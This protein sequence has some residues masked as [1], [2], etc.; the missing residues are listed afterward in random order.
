MTG[1]IERLI[2]ELESDDALDG[3]ERLRQRI[4][5]LDRLESWLVPGEGA[6]LAGPELY[7]RAKAICGRFEAVNARLYEAIRD[8][9]RRGAG[10]NVFAQHLA[11]PGFELVSDEDAGGEGYDS[12]DELVGGVLQLQEPRAEAVRL[13]HEMVAYQPTPA[14]H[15]LDLIGRTGLTERD[16]LVD[17]GSGLGHV[18][19]VTAI[20]MEA[21]CIGIEL[22]GAYV[23]CARRCAEA[24]ELRNVTF[25]KQDVRTADLSE[26]TVFYLYTPFTGGILRTVLDRLRR[27]AARRAI[28]VCTFGPCAAT[29]A[30]EGWLEAKGAVGTRRISVFTSCG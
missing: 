29:V 17:L 1:G 19:L 9:I 3:P 8:D 28:R 2:E 10:R 27:E 15:I 14:R 20:C 18:P 21:R 25:V 30:E 23:E 12:L 7:E 11:G 22:E 26:G 16:V 24:L 5:A 6:R 4:E 13:E